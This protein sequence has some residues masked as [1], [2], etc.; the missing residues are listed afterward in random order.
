M[1]IFPLA[2]AARSA[3][4]YSPPNYESVSWHIA[5]HTDIHLDIGSAP[6]RQEDIQQGRLPLCA[7]KL[8][9]SNK[10]HICNEYV[11]VCS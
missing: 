5:K 6:S 1:S 11:R 7:G 8:K 4:P 2:E 3:V 10:F 9:E